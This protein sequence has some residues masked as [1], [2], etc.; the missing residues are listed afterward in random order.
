[1]NPI[2]TEL[3]KQDVGSTRKLAE[4]TEK[5]IQLSDYR[6]ERESTSTSSQKSQRY[7][8]HIEEELWSRSSSKKDRVPVEKV[9]FKNI[10][11]ANRNRL[12]E[13]FYRITDAIDQDLALVE[14]SNCFDEWKDLL[15]LLAR[16]ADYMTNNHRKILGSLIAV[17]RESDITDLQG[18]TLRELQEATNVLRQPRVTRQ[19]SKRVIARLSSLDIEITIPLAPD[20]LDE[21]DSKTLDAMMT[22]I[23]EKSRG[24]D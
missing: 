10:D 15:E 18:N 19:D 1:M 22:R 2:N 8:G 6:P 20:D 12:Q 16:K 3:I 9:V 14:R 24:E 21:G 11:A 13:A 17:T 7:M 5:V 23:L 4:P